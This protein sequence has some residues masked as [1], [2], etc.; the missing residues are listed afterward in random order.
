M[1][2]LDRAIAWCR[3]HGYASVEAAWRHSGLDDDS[4]VQ[5]ATV[6]VLPSD[7]LRRLC[8]WC[9]RQALAATSIH[10][11]HD[12][13]AAAEACVNGQGGEGV[14]RCTI[15]AGEAAVRSG[16]FL[17][18]PEWNVASFILRADEWALS[19]D[20]SVLAH[21]ARYAVRLVDMVLG[22][23]E[24]TERISAY[25]RAAHPTIPPVCEGTPS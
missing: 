25:L 14:L 17:R 3:E 15:R 4:R 7:G 9:A 12:A 21:H 19:S 6:P 2:E 8:C 20:A 13:L 22:Y 1:N 11:V 18:S 10:A 24:A 16:P 5:L 23:P